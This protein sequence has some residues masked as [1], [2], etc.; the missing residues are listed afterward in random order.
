MRPAI[1]QDD[2]TWSRAARPGSVDGE[3]HRTS[4]LVFHDLSVEC[5]RR[6]QFGL[7]KRHQPERRAPEDLTFESATVACQRV[8]RPRWRAV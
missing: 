2:R 8:V 7:R 3:Q 4:P 1:K 6:E 5:L